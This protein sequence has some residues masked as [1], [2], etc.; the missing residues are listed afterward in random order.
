VGPDLPGLPALL[1]AGI[2]VGEAVRQGRGGVLGEAALRI[3]KPGEQGIHGWA[4]AG[5]STTGALSSPSRSTASVT[6]SPGW[7]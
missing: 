4:H 1:G 2:R 3:G 5:R 6:V 7:R